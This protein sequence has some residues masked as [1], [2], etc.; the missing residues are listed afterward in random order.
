MSYRERLAAEG[1]G[2]GRGPQKHQPLPGVNKLF[3]E[4]MTTQVPSTVFLC[5]DTELGS[6]S[7]LVNPQLCA[8]WGLQRRLQSS[9]AELRCRAQVQRRWAGA[10]L[11]P[12]P[13]ACLLSLPCLSVSLTHTRNEAVQKSPLRQN[14][15]VAAGV[16]YLSVPVPGSLITQDPWG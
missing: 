5:C 8:V 3:L 9:G 7:H 12:G 2:E 14:W 4:L 13:S 6:D 15:Y 1:R 10:G 16:G 11:V